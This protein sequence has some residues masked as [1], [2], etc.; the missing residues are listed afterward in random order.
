MKVI[1]GIENYKPLKFCALT[2]GTFDGVHVGHQKIIRRLVSISK[3]KNIHPVVLTFSPHP[4]MILQS[5]TSV[6]LIDTIEEKID[7]LK[8]L[9]IGTLIIH[10]FSKSFSR[11]TA[12][13]FVRDIIVKSLSVKYLIIG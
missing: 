9:N 12:N 1:Y 2:I 3:S 6:K 10:P 8:H 4:R 13:E 5:D 7:I 11:M